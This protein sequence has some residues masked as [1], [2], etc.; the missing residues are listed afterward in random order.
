MLELF[1]LYQTH[2]TFSFFKQKT[3]INPIYSGNQQ[4]ELFLDI[5]YFVPQKKEMNTKIIPM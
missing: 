1:I 5:C 4:V 2:M 3:D